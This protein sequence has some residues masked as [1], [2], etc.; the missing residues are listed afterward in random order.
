METIQ[1]DALGV[2]FLV[3]AADSNGSV[4]VFECFGP[5][6]GT[7]GRRNARDAEAPVGL[8][9]ASALRE[10]RNQAHERTRELFCR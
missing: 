5:A 4:S 9:R 10:K 1:L 6:A 2:C 8:A 3:D 7:H